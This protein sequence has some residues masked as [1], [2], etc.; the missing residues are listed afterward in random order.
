MLL[1]E[2]SEKKREKAPL[3]ACH[4]LGSFVYVITY[5][6]TFYRHIAGI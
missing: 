4:S 2:F 3:V 6:N 1:R 5:A